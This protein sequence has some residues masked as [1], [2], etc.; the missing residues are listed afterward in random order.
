[1]MT[2]EQSGGYQLSVLTA[3]MARYSPDS[4]ARQDFTFARA[5]MLSEATSDRLADFRVS[6]EIWNYWSCVA[7]GKN[8][9]YGSEGERMRPR[10]KG[11]QETL[12]GLELS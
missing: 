9:R 2:S 7:A 10:G 8:K 4:A 6:D 5:E 1:M 12:D 3:I 11:A